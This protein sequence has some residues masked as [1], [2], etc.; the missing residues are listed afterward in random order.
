MKKCTQVSNKIENKHI[1]YILL[2]FVEAGN[3]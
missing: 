3:Y 1:K 2:K